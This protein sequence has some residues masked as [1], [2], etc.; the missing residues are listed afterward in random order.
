MEE[1]VLKIIDGIKEIV[2]GILKE[3]VSIVKGFSERQ[4][5]SLA[6][7]TLLVKTNIEKGVY[8]EKQKEFFLN[9]L[10]FM[11]LNFVSTLQGILIVT[12]EKIWNALIKYLYE[13]V[14]AVS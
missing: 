3:D 4:L 13:I 6:L 2:S 9:E 10:E 1:N 14:G 5:N 11:A 7:Q 12:I 8:N